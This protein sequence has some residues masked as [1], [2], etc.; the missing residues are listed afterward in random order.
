MRVKV[1]PL[2]LLNLHDLRFHV[3]NLDD[4]TSLFTEQSTRKR[5][6]VGEGTLGR[7]GFVLANDA[8]CLRGSALARNGHHR[9]ETYLGRTI[10]RGND[11]SARA[12]SCPI[13]KVARGPGNRAR[14]LC[15][16]SRRLL[17]FE[18]RSLPQS[19]QG[20]AR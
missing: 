7:V 13:A 16:N 14:I 4:V 12:P 6:N 20:R 8:K 3:P 17:I 10:R 9:A 18:P 11:F 1:W 19:L 5:R 2:P 15:S